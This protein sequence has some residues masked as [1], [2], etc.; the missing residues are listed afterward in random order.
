[1]QR[2]IPIETE[3]GCF[4]G[5]DCIYLDDVTFED[6]TTTLV[7]EGSINGNLCTVPQPSSFVSYSLRFRGVLALKI[8]ELDSWDYDCESS[9]DEVHDS[10]WVRSLGGKVT[11]A[12]RHFCVQ[13]YDDVFDVVCKTYQFEIQKTA[14]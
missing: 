13:T 8:V 5:R 11:P 9:F 14:A 2:R 10:E 4:Q 6:G 7:L 1:M 12:Y 3:L